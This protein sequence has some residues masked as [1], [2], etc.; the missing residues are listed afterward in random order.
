MQ[1]ILQGPRADKFFEALVPAPLLFNKQCSGSAPAP[2]LLR[3]FHFPVR[4]F[5]S[6]HLLQKGTLIK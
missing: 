1:T 6:Q 5:N 3:Q 2:D 4:D